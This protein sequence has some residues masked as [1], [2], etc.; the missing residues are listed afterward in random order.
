MEKT[1]TSITNVRGR[2][3]EV[4]DRSLNI[5]YWTC[6]ECGKNGASYPGD[7]KFNMLNVLEQMQVYNILSGHECEAGG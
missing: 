4:R 1:T 2:F 3:S 7:N 5:V 6:H